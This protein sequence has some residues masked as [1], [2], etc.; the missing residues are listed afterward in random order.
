MTH[1]ETGAS[2]PSEYELKAWQALVSERA[3]PTRRA[4]K[5]LEE[6]AG[7]VVSTATSSGAGKALALGARN[8]AAVISKAVPEG[9]KRLV[10]SAGDSAGADWVG[11][12]A[13]ATGRTLMRVSRIGLTPNSVVKRH[14]RKGHE[15]SRL[16]DVRSLDLE[17]VDKV[18]GRNLDFAYAAIGAASGAG[19]GFMITGG[20]V[21]VSSGVGAA[22]GAGTVAGA[23]A[24]D[25][26]AV[27]GLS[28]RAVGQV[29]LSYG[30]DPEDP[31][32]KAFVASVV[33]FSTASTAAAKEA[34]FADIV[35]LTG[36]L[37]RGKSWKLLNETVF[38]RVAQALAK[39]ISQKLTQRSLGKLI[40]FAG[41]GI[42]AVMNFATLEGVVDAANIAYRRRF[43]LDKYPDI[44]EERDIDVVEKFADLID[45][46]ESEEII[47]I[48]KVLSELEDQ[49]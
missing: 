31:A 44:N 21:V 45:D 36:L 30:Y 3:R 22:P 48:D 35:R 1:T 16:L 2:S 6:R 25:L 29:A 12:A 41:V 8:G 28:S 19:T 14:Q 49:P 46:D 15:V 10:R 5:A 7:R 47:T 4:A 38:S 26:A 11:E 24:I 40:P 33:N 34:A 23:M 43:L 17:L 32:E 39:S 9:A 18:R 20:T 13:H 27:I 37:V 42:G